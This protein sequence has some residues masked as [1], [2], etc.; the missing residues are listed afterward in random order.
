LDIEFW[1][2]LLEALEEDNLYAANRREWL[3]ASKYPT[4][5]TWNAQVERD[6]CTFLNTL[7]AA[8][9]DILGL[10]IRRKFTADYCTTKL[11]G[12]AAGRKPD[13]TLFPVGGKPKDTGRKALWR[14]VQCCLEMKNSNSASGTKDAIIQLAGEPLARVP[15]MEAE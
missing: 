11:V 12:H 14:L 7:A 5:V 13:I 8:I 15:K 2:H 3:P 1:E 4:Q 6:F 10:P 9:A